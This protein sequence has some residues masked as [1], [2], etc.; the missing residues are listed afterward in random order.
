M[1]DWEPNAESVASQLASGELA[2]VAG[3]L[4]VLWSLRHD[5]APLPVEP[6]DH[7]VLA[8][9]AAMPPYELWARFFEVI[10][11]YPGFVPDPG[12][13]RRGQLLAE[14]LLRFGYDSPVYR[15]AVELRGMRDRSEGVRGAVEVCGGARTADEVDTAG[16][17][18]EYLLEYEED[19]E[20]VRQG[21][22]LWPDEH[23]LRI[24]LRGLV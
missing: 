10:C 6:F 12:P 17:L 16:R 7:R 9:G 2:Q 24:G 3:A 11:R 8:V 19:H 4:D 14:A 18:L 5:D 21:I 15:A 1:G 13:R 20:A 22:R 23:P